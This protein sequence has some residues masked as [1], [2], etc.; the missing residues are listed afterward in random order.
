MIPHRVQLAK[1]SVLGLL[2][3]VWVRG[4]LQDHGSLKAASPK[5]APNLAEAHKS[6]IP[7]PCGSLRNLEVAKKEGVSVL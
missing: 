6:S 3:E 2:I 7:A 4:H 5:A 1:K